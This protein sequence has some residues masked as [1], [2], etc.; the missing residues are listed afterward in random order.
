MA[1]ADETEQERSKPSRQLRTTQDKAGT[2]YQGPD[3]RVGNDLAEPRYGTEAARGCF[4][5]GLRNTP[6]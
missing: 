5:K 4:L 3:A 2:S 1:G 6:H